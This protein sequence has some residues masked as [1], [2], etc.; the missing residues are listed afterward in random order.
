MIFGVLR[1]GAVESI[2]LVCLISIMVSG[3]IITILYLY[4]VDNRDIF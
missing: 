4:P 2:I 1:P 3:L